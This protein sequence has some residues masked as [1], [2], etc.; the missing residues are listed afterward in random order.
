M[1]KVEELEFFV[2]QMVSLVNVLSNGYAYESCSV[3]SNFLPPP[4]LY[5]PWNSPG[6][7]TGVGRGS[8]QPRNQTQISCIAGGFF[9]IRATKE[10]LD[11]YVMKNHLPAGLAVNF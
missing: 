7:N 4:G 11:S 10:A 2:V 9:I 8:S 6:Q 3:V 1:I 5:S